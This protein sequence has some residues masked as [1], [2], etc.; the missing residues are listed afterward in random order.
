MRACIRADG[1]TT[2][3][4]QISN[5]SLSSFTAEVAI[6]TSFHLCSGK[7][8][9]EQAKVTATQLLDEKLKELAFK[10]AACTLIDGPGKANKAVQSDW[11]NGEDW[12]TQ[13]LKRKGLEPHGVTWLY[14]G[15]AGWILHSAPTC[16]FCVDHFYTVLYCLLGWCMCALCA[17]NVT[18]T[19]S[20]R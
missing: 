10:V 2:H 19:L 7:P 20:I 9:L 13:R 5:L 14:E 3:I 18:H 11:R 16:M 8:F 4:N 15:T 6:N 1:E 17:W 12:S